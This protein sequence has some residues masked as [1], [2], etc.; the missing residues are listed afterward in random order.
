MSK[1][2]E[3]IT[4][5]RASQLSRGYTLAH[6]AKYTNNE[7]S[8]AAEAHLAAA[9]G[10][11]QD[12]RDLWPFDLEFFRLNTTSSS[13]AKAGALLAAEIDRRFAAGECTESDFGHPFPREI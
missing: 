7:L 12:A 1:G 8:V 11:E 4:G 2:I 9:M 6:D 13:L 5:E 10:D 3:A